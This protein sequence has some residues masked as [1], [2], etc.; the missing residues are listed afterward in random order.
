MLFLFR[1]NFIILPNRSTFIVFKSYNA[2]GE[3]QKYWKMWR[4][5][6]P[7]I[8]WSTAEADQIPEHLQYR[9]PKNSDICCR[10]FRPYEASNRYLTLSKVDRV[11]DRATWLGPQPLTNNVI[12][13]LRAFL[14][15]SSRWL[16]NEH[17][18]WYTLIKICETSYAF[19]KYLWKL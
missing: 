13:N 12:R 16:F 18:H 5:G 2:R 9:I 1:W 8:D 7:T 11:L 19:L 14:H 6:S 10:E 15:F 3:H 4:N 17:C